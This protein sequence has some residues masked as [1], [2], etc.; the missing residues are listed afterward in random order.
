M[1][2]DAATFLSQWLLDSMH[3][4]TALTKE[5][6]CEDGGGKLTSPYV[7]SQRRQHASKM[8]CALIDTCAAI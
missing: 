5:Y 8:T 7:S 1:A 6:V 4:V 3:G 2:I